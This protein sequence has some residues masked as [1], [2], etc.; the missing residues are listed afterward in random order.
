VSINGSV[1][2]PAVEDLVP[3][4][5]ALAQQ[6]GEIPS[7]NRIM[8][9][10]RVGSPKASAVRDALVT[11]PGL[12]SP[13]VDADEQPVDE[14]TPL[15][16]PVGHPEA[17]AVAQPARKAHKPLRSWPVFLIALPAAVAIWSG[18]VGLGSMTGFGV[19]HPLP[20]IWDSFSINTAV[21]LPIGVEAYA[22]YAL[23]AWLSGSRVPRTARRF[24]KWSAIASLVV[25]SA[26]QIAFHLLESRGVTAAPWQITTVVACLPVIVL[27][28]GAALAH[29]LNTDDEDQADA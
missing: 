28:M 25:G 20:G 22:A 23:K 9:E 5:A 15:V 17:A 3:Q 16:E 24:A 27:G 1:Y 7:R 11:D 29:L 26:G 18:W 6:I 10:F 19:V 4:A 2:P 8:K 21:T 13:T 12:V 14:P